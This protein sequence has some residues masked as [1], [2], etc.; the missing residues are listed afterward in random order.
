MYILLCFTGQFPLGNFIKTMLC[1]TKPI[2]LPVTP[3]KIQESIKA[4]NQSMSKQRT[5]VDK[6]L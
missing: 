3:Y 5:H 6:W 4:I 2:I 1:Q